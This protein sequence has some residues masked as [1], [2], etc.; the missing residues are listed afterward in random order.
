MMERR[1]SRGSE[2]RCCRGRHSNWK[3]KAFFGHGVFRVKDKGQNGIKHLLFSVLLII[4]TSLLSI[5]DALKAATYTG[6][7]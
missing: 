5:F 1:F 7:G 6:V 2:P 3:L 4:F